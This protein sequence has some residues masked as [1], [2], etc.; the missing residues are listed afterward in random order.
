[1]SLLTKRKTNRLVPL[2]RTIIHFLCISLSSELSVQSIP[3]I[4]IIMCTLFDKQREKKRP[5]SHNRQQSVHKNQQRP[6]KIS[7]NPDEM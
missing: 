5:T 2:L 1:M 6:I 3:Q 4:I 7:N